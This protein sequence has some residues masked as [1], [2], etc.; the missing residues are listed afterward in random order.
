M[1]ITEAQV[2]LTLTVWLV[3]ATA[4]YLWQFHPLIHP[5]AAALGLT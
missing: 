3:A 1:K 5:I 2:R 4:I